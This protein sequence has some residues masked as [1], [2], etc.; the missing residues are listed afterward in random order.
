MPVLDHLT[1]DA[2]SGIQSTSQ[3]AATTTHAWE[4]HSQLCINVSEQY[5]V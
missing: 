4:G 3:P 1:D 2:P 5:S